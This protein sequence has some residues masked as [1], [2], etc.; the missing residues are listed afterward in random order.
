MPQTLSV[1]VKIPIQIPEDQ[2]LIKKADFDLLQANDLLG[3][4]WK[5]DDVAKRLNKT[6]GWVYKHVLNDPKF[7]SDFANLKMQ[8]IVVKG[9]GRTAP[10]LFKASDFAQWLDRNWIRFD[11]GAK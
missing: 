5:V 9:E 6:R 8:G 2:V 4:T 10:W 3:R 1:D 11:W 7:K